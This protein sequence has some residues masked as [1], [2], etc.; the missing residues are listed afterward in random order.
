MSWYATFGITPS[1]GPLNA[2]PIGNIGML[3]RTE[4]GFIQLEL[5]SKAIK[6]SILSYVGMRDP[7]S[8]KTWGAVTE[9]GGSVQ[10]FRSIAPKGTIFLKG[11]YGVIDGTDTWKRIP[12]SPSPRLWPTSSTSKTSNTSPSASQLL[13]RPSRTTRITSPMAPRIL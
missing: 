7:Y 2:K 4:Q 10:L 8:G 11:S 13:T 5:Y 3:Y 12:T 6:E 9:S 1:G